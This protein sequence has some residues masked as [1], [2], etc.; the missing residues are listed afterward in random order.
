MYWP[1]EGLY[2]CAVSNV[3]DSMKRMKKINYDIG[4]Q[5]K[6]ILIKDIILSQNLLYT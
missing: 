6:N 2:L 1:G 3:L 4:L 5:T